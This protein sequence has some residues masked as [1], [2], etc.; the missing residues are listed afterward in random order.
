MP[1]LGS[2]VL[3]L[4]LSHGRLDA[5]EAHAL[6]TLDEIFQEEMWGADAEATE[7]RARVGADVALA[8]RLLRLSR[9]GAA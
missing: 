4:A 1:L 7:R 8:A 6:A 5:A 2:V 9:S 3:G